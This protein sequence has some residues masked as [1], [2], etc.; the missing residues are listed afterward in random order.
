MNGEPAYERLNVLLDG[1]AF[2]V[3]EVDGSP[4]RLDFTIVLASYDEDFC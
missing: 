2:G 4:R 1:I 3:H